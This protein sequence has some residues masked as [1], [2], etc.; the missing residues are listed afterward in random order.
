MLVTADTLP[1]SVDP[2]LIDT[3]SC[4]AIARVAA[5]PSRR[6]LLS[7]GTGA[8]IQ[9]LRSCGG[10]VDGA[11]ER[12]QQTQDA[13]PHGFMTGIRGCHRSDSEVIQHT[14]SDRRDAFTSTSLN[15][16]FGQT[17][18]AGPGRDPRS[19]EVLLFVVVTV[20]FFVVIAVVMF[21]LI[22]VSVIVMMVRV[23]AGMPIIAMMMLVFIAMPIS[24]MMVVMIV[25]VAVVS[26]MVFVLTVLAHSGFGFSLD[27][28]I[29]Y[30]R[31]C[32]ECRDDQR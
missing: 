18:C 25:G 9:R 3:S 15:G 7:W 26:V 13:D 27:V 19:G 4:P 28:I 12:Q 21:V 20:T 24:A 30:C 17:D 11:C 1:G 8:T 2:V 31:R 23:L 6:L 5:W 14:L 22:R 16:Y 32:T 10:T 29:S